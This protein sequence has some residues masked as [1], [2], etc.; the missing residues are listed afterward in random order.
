[1][2]YNIPRGKA[3]RLPY[4]RS[5]DCPKAGL[6]HEVGSSSAIHS[7]PHN[8]LSFK[9]LFVC[10]GLKFRLT[11]VFALA[12]RRICTNRVQDVGGRREPCGLTT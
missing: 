11:S 12:S 4:R 8:V 3:F 10:P 6:G 7:R 9:V 2:K 5:I 1:M